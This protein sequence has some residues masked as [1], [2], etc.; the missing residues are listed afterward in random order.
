MGR[1]KLSKIHLGK[2]DLAANIAILLTVLLTFGVTMNQLGLYGSQWKSVLS[3]DGFTGTYGISGW[4]LSGLVGLVGKNVMIYHILNAAL[5]YFTGSVIYQFLKILGWDREYSLAAALLFLVFPGFGLPAAAFD[6]TEILVGLLSGILSLWFYKK[7]SSKT[8]KERIIDFIIGFFVAILAIILA[9]ATAFFMGIAGCLFFAWHLRQAFSRQSTSILAGL[10][11]LILSVLIPA[12]LLAWNFDFSRNTLLGAFKNWFGAYLLT[13]RKIIAF[14]AGGLN[15]ILYFIA[16]AAVICGLALL[17]K[18]ME[19]DSSNIQNPEKNYIFVAAV[20]ALA[21]LVF[22]AA[23]GVFFQSSGTEYSKDLNMII[24]G[25]FVALFIVSLIRIFFQT[26]YQVL[27]LA[28]MIGLS[29]GAR[30]QVTG[31]FADENHR[32]QNFLAQ[33]QVRGDSFEVGTSL[34]VEQLPFELTSREAVEALVRDRMQASQDEAKS[35]HIIPADNPAVRE[36]LSNSDQNSFELRV[37][38]ENVLVEKN[39]MVALWMPEGKCLEIL[40]TRGAYSELPQGLALASQYSNPDKI[41]VKNMSDVLQHDKFRTTIEPDTCFETQLIQRFAAKSEW[42]NVIDTY[43]KLPEAAEHYFDFYLIKPVLVAMMEKGNQNGA[44][45]ITQDYASDPEL[46][47]SI[48]GIWSEIISQNTS[49]KEV[50]GSARQAFEK[51]G[52]Q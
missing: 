39:N 19:N 34:L 16:L 28:I 5:L 43:S 35:I 31:R 14:P 21:G 6:L 38:T 12:S 3:P 41:I 45:K 33:L 40:E 25:L 50:V 2:V 46:K 26:E 18:H 7:A 51:T 49:N 22:L 29:G 8:G 4:I 42:D 15:V 17:F 44:L 24:A 48:C 47:K 37:G 32:I 9:P 23:S 20:S 27:L 30:Y 13:W 1:G 36:F 52:C 11:H 10:S